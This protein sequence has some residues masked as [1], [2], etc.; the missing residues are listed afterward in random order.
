MDVRRGLSAGGLISTVDQPKNL[1]TFSARVETAPRSPIFREAYR[2]CRA[3]IPVQGAYKW[4]GDKKARH[5]LA[6][7]RTDGRPLVCAGLWHELDGVTSCTIL[8]TAPTGV[9]AQIHNRMPLLLLQDRLAAWFDPA[10]PLAQ[11]QALTAPNN[12]FLA[13]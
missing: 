3:L 12:L 8:T 5:P 2:T 6:I 11:V 7:T 10:A 9:F 1:S 4:T 13:L